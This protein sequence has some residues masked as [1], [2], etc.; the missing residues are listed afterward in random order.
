MDDIAKE[1]L[2]KQNNSIQFYFYSACVFLDI[3][4]K[5]RYGKKEQEVLSHFSMSLHSKMETRYIM[6]FSL[7]AQLTYRAFHTVLNPG[8]KTCRLEFYFFKS[9]KRLL[10]TN[11]N[12]NQKYLRN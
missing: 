12:Q 11:W 4:A 3:V 10:S 5:Q 6:R 1:T 7:T 2:L 9:K 8:L